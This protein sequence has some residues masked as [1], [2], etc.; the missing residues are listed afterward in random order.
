MV[1]YADDA[2][3]LTIGL[4]SVARRMGID[5]LRRHW[6]GTEDGLADLCRLTGSRCPQRDS[7]AERGVPKM[8][9]VTFRSAPQLFWPMSRLRITADRTH[10]PALL[11]YQTP[12]R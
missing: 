12:L 7:C 3:I 11:S 6:P 2:I 9:A 10:S 4:R 5:E 8:V 1:G